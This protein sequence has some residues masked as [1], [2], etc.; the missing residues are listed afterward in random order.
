[1]RKAE[2]DGD[3]V[4]V[5]GIFV[6]VDVL[7]G[8]RDEITVADGLGVGIVVGVRFSSGMGGCEGSRAENVQAVAITSE[9]MRTK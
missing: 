5:E 6:G 3:R 2:S 1:M 4:G 7:A 9:P 8:V